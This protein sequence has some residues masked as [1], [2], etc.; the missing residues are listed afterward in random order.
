MVLSRFPLGRLARGSA[1][2]LVLS[3]GAIGYSRGDTEGLVSAADRDPPAYLAA[4]EAQAPRPVDPAAPGP[5]APGPAS[6]G[7]ANLGDDPILDDLWHRCQQ[8][9]GAACDQLF[10]QSPVG[11]AYEAFGVSCGNRPDILRCGPEMDLPPATG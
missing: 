8:G 4:V 7:P 2:A 5:A 6:K 11:S 3:V 10:D 1:L 9:S